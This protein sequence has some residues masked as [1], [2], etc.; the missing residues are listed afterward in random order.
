MRDA[1]DILIVALDVPGEEEALRLCDRLGPRL[2]R[3]K[4]GLELY[5]AEGPGIVPALLSRGLDIFLDL[6]FHDIPNTVERACAEAARLG[7]GIMNV[8]AG[9]GEAMMEA[10]VRG[11]RAGAREG[12]HPVPQVLGVTVLTS[13]SGS[14]LP[15]YYAGVPVAERVVTLARAA[16]DAGLDGVVASPREVRPLREAL[17]PEF[18]LLTPGIRFPG[19]DAGDQK[20]VT[21]PSAAV[22]DGAD[23][24]VM[25]RPITADPYPRAA[26][27]RALDEIS[28]TPIR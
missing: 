13:L 10:A 22:A 24:L 19:G 12:G 7:A 15:G 26:M 16:R 2:R 20:R 8:H 3:V 25:G 9:G 18:V 4:V 28:R 5:V 14:E 6:K 17:G 23:Y 21:S 11:A 27:G 1:A